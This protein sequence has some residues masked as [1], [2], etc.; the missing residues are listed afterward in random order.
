M[1]RKALTEKILVLGVDGF[2]P[3]L[4]KKFMDQGK[5]PNLKKFME[6]GSCRK[7]LVLLG[8]MPTVTPPLWTTL[9]TGAYV[10]THGI[11]C[12]F[13]QDPDNLDSIFYNLDSRRC[14]AE[15]LWN[16]FAEEGNKKTL[17]WHWP[18]S[19]WPPTSESSNLHVVE[20]TQPTAINAGIGI[21]DM[22]KF[23]EASETFTE[24]RFIPNSVHLAAGTGCVID[25][26]ED[27]LAP[28]GGEVEENAV[29]AALAGRSKEGIK[30]IFTSE[31]DCEVYTIADMP[32]DK[33]QSAIKPAKGWA[34]A[35]AG[36]KEFLIIVARGLMRKP[37]LILKNEAGIYDTVAIYQ[38]KKETEPFVVLKNGETKYGVPDTI[39]NKADQVVPC[40]RS[41]ILR[42]LAE[43]GS[44]I[45]MLVDGAM[46]STNDSLFHPK[47]LLPEVVSNIGPIP[48][49]IGVSCT[50]PE[51]AKIYVDS[52][53]N[54]TQWQANCLTYFMEKESY[55]VIFS[56]LHNVDSCGH[57]FWHYGKHQEEWVN[58]ELKYQILIEEVYMQT[59]RYIEKFLPYVENGWTTVIT[60]DHG[61]IISEHHGIVL[62]EMC[63]VNVPIMRELG[64][65]E[66]LKDENG[67]DLMEIDWTKTK[68][69]AIRGNHMYINVKGRDKH[70]IVEPADQYAV[71]QQLI[72]DL[73][74][75]RDP[76]TGKRVISL[77]IRNK[78]AALF[79]MSGPECGDIIYFKEEGFN[80]IHCD[81]LS[82]QCGY[83]DTSVSPIFLAAGPG[84]KGNFKTN[85][86]I[87]Q[88]DV[89]PTLAVLGGVRMPA[90]CEG[91]PVYQILSEEY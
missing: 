89:A 77:A 46:D 74:S 25:D 69:I 50:S 56:H 71:E 48:T 64:Y 41:Y 54:Y 66:L 78:E 44:K 86:V 22:V 60:S 12:F 58:D 81:S 15:P 33:V 45:D 53:E 59:D 57:L 29:K 79:G 20:G 67:N 55:D 80:I 39:M 16:V 84:I 90:Q 30:N 34:N 27:M 23:V 14:K 5:M 61:L 72:S 47:S 63:G 49:R 18:G 73:Y 28:A 42:S 83:F 91:A 32:K 26:M 13:A 68:A 21:M 17:V 70:G 9:A 31:Q 35:P 82:T 37:A 65:T 52:W 85:R 8:A 24:T 4:A 62:G 2:E 19:S 3:K 38:S 11:T 87:R 10:E 51:L 75:Y 88:V 43:D 40:N 6:M 7:D 1:V 36:A 76:K